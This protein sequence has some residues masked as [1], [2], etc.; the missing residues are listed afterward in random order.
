MIS[1]TEATAQVFWTAFQAM[2]QK[3]REAIVE[4]FLTEKNFMEDLIDVVILR[5]REN[6]PSRPL[7]QYLAGRKRKNT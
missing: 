4:R 7:E 3:E 2:P 6:E 5:Q 1:A